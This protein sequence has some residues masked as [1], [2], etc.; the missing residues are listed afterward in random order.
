MIEHLLSHPILAANPLGDIISVIVFI[1]VIISGLSQ[2]LS[3]AKGKKE[4]PARR[5]G[6]PVRPS[7]NTLQDEVE[8]FK[9]M[10]EQ[11]RQGEDSGRPQGQTRNPPPA[12][13]PRSQIPARPKGASHEPKPGRINPARAQG[14]SQVSKSEAKRQKKNAERKKLGG[15]I[16]DRHIQVEQDLQT[17]VNKHVQQHLSTQT[18]ADTV[19]RDLASQVS[20]SVR[21]HLGD[22]RTSAA[23]SAGERKGTSPAANLRKLLLS[24]PGIRQAL[25][26][27]EILQP[28]LARRGGQRGN[29]P[30]QD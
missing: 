4:A 13:Q 15:E 20:E 2:M 12:N 21:E 22:S 28:P 8:K 25:I 19:Q 3:G 1:F 11:M 6:E 24:G 16:A 10:V 7:G 14:G 23:P 18:L 26:V 29:R 27:N 5:A 9:Q 17:Q 30:S